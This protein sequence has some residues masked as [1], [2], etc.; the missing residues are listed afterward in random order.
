M[1][2]TLKLLADPTRLRLL[3]ILEQ[4]DF[5]VQDL[6]TI[7]AMGQSRISRHL[8]LMVREGLLQLDKQGTWHYYRLAPSN[9]FYVEIRDA[10]KNRF[11]MLINYDRDMAGLLR[12][13]DERRRRNRQFFDSHAGDLDGMH[14]ALLN[15]P[16]YR[17]DL[18]ALV[19]QGGLIVE[20]GVGTGRLLPDLAGI[21]DRVIGVDHSPAM[22]DL[23]RECAERVPHGK[24]DLR[25]AEMIHLPVETTS[26][27]TVVM[28]QVLH[29]AEL[30]IL[31]L[32]EINRILKPGGLL[33]IADLVRHDHDWVRQ[34]LAD[35]WLGFSEQELLTWCTE[36]GFKKLRYQAVGRTG[37]QQVLL[38]TAIKI[39][40]LNPN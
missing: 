36:A 32:K 31:V 4:G 18:F 15:L 23:A 6:T 13:T 11:N 16:D 2:S 25:L 28:N 33:L 17:R 30:P 38:L 34:Q 24:I 40:P 5:T 37:Q 12:V 9:D 27:D 7:L 1:L 8:K 39:D 14:E 19:P 20:I 10:V 35:Q 21:G 26:A 3:R 29:H 22:I